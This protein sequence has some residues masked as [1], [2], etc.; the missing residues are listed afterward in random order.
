MGAP[1]HDSSAFPTL[2]CVMLLVVHGFQTYQLCD[3]LSFQE[4]INQTP[5][6]L[7]Q[8]L[9]PEMAFMWAVVVVWYFVSQATAVMSFNARPYRQLLTV[10]VQKLNAATRATGP[11][12]QLCS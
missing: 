1:T 2:L 11:A 7:P 9:T 12:T 3:G 6:F 4:G 10:A 8:T 5:T